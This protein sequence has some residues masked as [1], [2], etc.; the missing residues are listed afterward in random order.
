MPH[1]LARVD[2]ID[3]LSTAE[4]RF[5]DDL[6]QL[7]AHY[8]IAPTF[9]RVFG[10]LLLQDNPLSLDEIA[11][12]LQ[13]SKST[14][15]VITRELERSGIV[16]RLGVPGSRR[17]LYEANDDMT[18]I[19]DA[20]FARIRASVPVLQE[21]EALLRR[22]GRARERLQQMLLLHDFWL[23]EGGGIVER[24]RRRRRSMR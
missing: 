21:A 18:P 20:M 23:T 22:P 3:T 19:F 8:G 1:A 6:G 13:V 12:Q 9:G 15:S 14:I 5:I 17:V 2:R 10:L 16:R 4:R 24:W 11:A 7:Y